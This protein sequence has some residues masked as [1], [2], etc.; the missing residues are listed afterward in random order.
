MTAMPI[1]SCLSTAALDCP[2]LSTSQLSTLGLV[3]HIPGC[4]RDHLWGYVLEYDSNCINPRSSFL[5]NVT[6]VNQIGS[7]HHLETEYVTDCAG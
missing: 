1:N 2:S 3:Q 6:L 4:V 7:I 5:R